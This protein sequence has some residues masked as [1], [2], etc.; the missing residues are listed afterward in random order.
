MDWVTGEGGR[1]CFDGPRMSGEDGGVR[2]LVSD[3]GFG[4]GFQGEVDGLGWNG[5]YR[6]RGG[7]ADGLLEQTVSSQRT[8]ATSAPKPPEAHISC[9][10]HV[11]EALQVWDF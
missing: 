5:F 7:R 2:Y 3:E 11:S 10:Q 1:K 9:T 8:A 6:V 4:R